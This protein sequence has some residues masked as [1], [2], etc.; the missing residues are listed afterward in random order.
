MSSTE[1]PEN[2]PETP[3]DREPGSQ[4]S[5]EDAVRYIG[6]ITSELCDIARRA[7]LDLLAYFLEMARME[8]Q[9]IVKAER[10]A[11]SGR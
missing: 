4:L 10:K 2:A 11:R 8:A 5:R 1:A 7:D 3:R 9:E 6:A